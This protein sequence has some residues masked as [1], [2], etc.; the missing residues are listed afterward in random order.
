[1][2]STNITSSGLIKSN[3]GKLRAVIVNSHTNGTISF[4]DGLTAYNETAD[5]ATGTLTFTGTV[6]DGETVTIGNEVYEFDT[7]DEV[8]AGNILV[9]VSGGATASAAVTALVTA[10]TAESALVT[11]VD[12]TG[13]TV[14]ITAVTAGLV[15]NS[16]VTDTDCENGSFGAETLTGG[17]DA[18][19]RIMNT[20]TFATGSQVYDLHDISFDEGLYATIGGTANVTIVYE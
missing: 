7:D 9:D 2:K 1:M 15:G 20:F 11:A 13:D 16:I 8:I 12:G 17:A 4:V 6:A 18:N 10:I 19:K 14:D 5:A 3:F